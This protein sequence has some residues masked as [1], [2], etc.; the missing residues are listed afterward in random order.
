M[1]Y[2]FRTMIGRFPGRSLLAIALV[3]GVSASARADMCVIDMGSNTFR[4]IAG[5]F[6]LGRYVQT[7]IEKR[8]LGV[9]DD[10]AKHGRISDAKLE[11]IEQAL[12]SFK[13]ACAKQG[14]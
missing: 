13:A 7:A 8:T 9:G 11:E 6:E 2:A 10:V 14:V 1:T 4:R 3:T 12:S 5:S